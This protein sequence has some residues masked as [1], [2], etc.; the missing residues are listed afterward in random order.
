MQKMPLD[1]FVN[2]FDFAPLPANA[3]WVPPTWHDRLGGE[4][5]IRRV[6]AEVKA[7]QAGTLY[8]EESESA[9][10]SGAVTLAT[11][12]VAAN[13]T[14]EIP[15]T[16]LTRQ[17]YRLRYVN[18]A[19]A[20]GQRMYLFME[21]SG[22][23]VVD[24]AMSGVSVELTADMSNVTLG[25]SQIPDTQAIPMKVTG[26][27][28]VGYQSITVDNAAK[29]LTPPQGATR[30]L[31][32]VETAELRYR[33]DGT[34]PT[35]ADGHLADHRDMIVLTSAT[36]IAGFR[37]IRTGATSAVIRVSYSAG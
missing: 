6:R 29:S 24:A 31:I 34:A 15:W 11:V 2:K 36:D 22:R 32:T 5:L 28:V 26:A 8:L 18:G 20:Q 17:Y 23:P 3:T 12:P 25:G 13:T 21:T 37:A 27:S 30:A 14:T 35:A 19:V 7:N 1:S 10:G 33:M 9:D 16:N 4:E